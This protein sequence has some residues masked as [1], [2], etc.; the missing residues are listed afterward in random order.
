MG[1]KR[2]PDFRFG[3][4]PLGYHLTGK[5]TGKDYPSNINT[6]PLTPRFPHGFLLSI[7]ISPFLK[8]PLV[9]ALFLLFKYTPYN[10]STNRINWFRW[11]KW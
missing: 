6:L 9:D 7:R 2:F 11:Y 5:V 3:V 8:V 4:L 1:C 10:F